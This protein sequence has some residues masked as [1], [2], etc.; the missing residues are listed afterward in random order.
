MNWQEIYF[1]VYEKRKWYLSK[2]IAH[3]PKV[4]QS[5]LRLPAIVNP[6]TR[7]SSRERVWLVIGAFFGILFILAVFVSMQGGA[8]Q[9]RAD[10]KMIPVAPTIASSSSPGQMSRTMIPN[11][12]SKS[13]EKSAPTL[14]T[15]PVPTTRPAPPVVVFNPTPTS[16]PCPG[17]NCNP[18]GYNFVA[19]KLIYNPPAGFCNYFACVPNFNQF[20]HMGYVVEC[21]DGM[22]SQFL[23]RRATCILHGGMLRSLYAH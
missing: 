8:Q 19:G 16:T 5:E 14:P 21:N 4:E 22:Y 17:V 13:L 7:L 2:H 12:P 11:P 18:W 6:T 15:T 20:H 10:Q 3:K 9:A 1:R 23:G